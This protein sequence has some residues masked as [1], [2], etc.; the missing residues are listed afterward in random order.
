MSITR[1]AKLFLEKGIMWMKDSRTRD[2]RKGYET[3][4][5]ALDDMARKNCCGIDCCDSSIYLRATNGTPV[6][7][8]IEIVE[9][10]P[11]FVFST[12]D[13]G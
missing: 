13:A 1:K 11:Q 9:G 10:N 8:N 12:P 4:N 2:G 3:L 6:K 7:V 5:D